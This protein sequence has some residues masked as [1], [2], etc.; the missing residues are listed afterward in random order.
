[1]RI[2]GGALRGRRLTAPPGHDV[3]PTADRAREGLFNILAH[4]AAFSDFSLAGARVVDAFAGTG[5]LGL[6]ALSRGAAHATFLE[7]DAAARQALQRNIAAL[8]QGDRCDILARD[9]TRPGRGRM[10]ASLVFLDPP[11]GMGLAEPAVTALAAAGW[12][13]ADAV[14]VVEHADGEA[15]AA[16]AGFE[17]VEARRYGAAAFCFMRWRGTE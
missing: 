3:R 12:L 16:P 11:Y 17:T 13:A 5:A 15:F 10:P 1:V 8:D 14:V 2:V 4:G 9:A 6:E 7:T